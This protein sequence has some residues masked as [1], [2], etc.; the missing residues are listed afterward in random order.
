[1]RPSEVVV[2]PHEVL[3]MQS[4]HPLV[5]SILL[6]LC[7][8]ACHGIYQARLEIRPDQTGDLGA[9]DLERAEEVFVEFAESHLYSLQEGVADPAEPPPRRIL[10][11]YRSPVHM[12][13]VGEQTHVTV[14]IFMYTL[15]ARGAQQ[16]MH[17]FAAELSERYVE[18][19]GREAVTISDEP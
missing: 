10:E 4:K 3:C 1:M 8:S 12:R 6:A 11:A 5:F 7:L 18:V 19:F 13:L 16:W 2:P 17:E 9:N 14:T 15:L